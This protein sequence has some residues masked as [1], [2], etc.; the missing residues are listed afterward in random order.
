MAVHQPDGR[1]TTTHS[2][3][4]EPRHATTPCDRELLERIQ[5]DDLDA[6]EIL[7]ARY[8]S[9]IYRTAYGLTGD[10]QAAEEVLQDTFARAWQ[11]RTTLILDVSPL[12]WLH[13]VALNLCY[14]RLGRRRLR[15][16]PIEE[17]THGNVRDGTV[18]PAER[19][20]R[21]ELRRIVRDGI[22]ALPPKHQAVVAL[23]YLQGLS[24]Q[25][26][27]EALD[28]ALGTVKSRLHYALRGLRAHLETDRRFGGAYR[29]EE[30]AARSTEAEVA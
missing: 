23:Y 19:A 8:R 30:E 12:P 29:A 4:A 14:S 21:Q 17:T 28:I 16:E 20:E 5:A 15:A 13:R 7:F 1:R 26:T 3:D 24:L 27:A 11:R 9:P 22:A 25:E 18:E 6:F 10:A 2:P